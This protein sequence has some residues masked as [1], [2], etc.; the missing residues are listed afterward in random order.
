MSRKRHEVRTRVY[1]AGPIS[2]GDPEGNC[3]RAIKMGFV[4]MDKG[5]APYVPHYS[6]FVDVDSV[7]GKGRY[8]QWISGDLSWIA[9]CQGLLRLSGESKGA[10]REVRWAREVGVP[11]FYDLQVLLDELK[12]TQIMEVTQ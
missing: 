4:L 5:Y 2:Q 10:D 3:R 7:A 8:E 12:P 9:T 11:V 1:V 6:W